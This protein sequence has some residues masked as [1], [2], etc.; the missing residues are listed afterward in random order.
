MDCPEIT[1]LRALKTSTLI[2]RKILSMILV[3]AAVVP[4]TSFSNAAESSRRSSAAVNSVL[5][6][7]CE[8]CML[9]L[10]IKLAVTLV[11]PL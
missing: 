1:P 3:N 2:P 7:R 10:E 4:E 9:I 11:T 8:A 5:G 6:D